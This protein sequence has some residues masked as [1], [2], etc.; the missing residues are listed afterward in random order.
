LTL[1]RILLRPTTP[2]GHALTNQTVR[3][4]FV[5]GRY[6]LDISTIYRGPHDE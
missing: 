4:A 3:T 6:A 5:V 1:Y 2:R